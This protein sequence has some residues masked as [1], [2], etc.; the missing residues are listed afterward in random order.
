MIRRLKP[1]LHKRS[2]PPQMQADVRK[3]TQIAR[4]LNNAELEHDI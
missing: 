1:L 3:L 4:C 2:L